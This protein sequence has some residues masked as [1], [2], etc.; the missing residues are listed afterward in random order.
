MDRCSVGFGAQCMQH[1]QQLQAGRYFA[2]SAFDSF[3]LPYIPTSNLDNRLDGSSAFLI[4]L[5]CWI[6]V[7]M[8]YN[9]YLC[10]KLAI[11]LSYRIGSYECFE[12]IVYRHPFHAD[13]SDQSTS[14]PSSSTS[15]PPSSLPSPEISKLHLD[16]VS[17][18]NK[19]E[20]LRLKA[21]ANK[22]FT[23]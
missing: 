16:D 23:C 18:E 7:V 13:M 3:I 19:Q 12:K 21:E 15:T 8:N 11:R 14:P 17:A 20:A 4:H 10:A 2:S 6:P 5:P 1:G 22:A 9:T